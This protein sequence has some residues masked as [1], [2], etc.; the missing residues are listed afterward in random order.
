M[1][2]V[3]ALLVAL[4]LTPPQTCADVT[5]CRQ[6]ALDAAARGEYELFHDLAWRTAQKGR[7]NDP[8]LMA[9]LAR[10]QSLSGRPGDALVMLRRL[11]QM[12]AAIDATGDD[13]RRVR[14][15]PGWPEVEAMLKG[16]PPP[17]VEPAAT[18]PPPARKAAEPVASTAAPS[19]APAPIATAL[20]A[21]AA[22]EETL[23]A[24]L[25]SI[26]PAGLAYDA[27]SRRFIVGDR[28]ENKL[29][30]FDEVFKRATDMAGAA[31]AGFFG[32]AA[33]EIDA[34]RGDLWVAN[35]SAA[36][37]AALHKLQLVSGRVLFEVAVPAE[38][39]PAA[40]ADAAVLPDGRVLALDALGRR[41]LAL[42][43]ARA[44]QRTADIAVEGA[45][46]LAAEGGFAYIAHP[47]G[48][49]RVDLAS[50]NSSA[51][52]GAP[53]GLLRI[54]AAGRGLVAVQSTAS[55]HRIVRIRFASQG[56]KVA[57]VDVLDPSAPMPDP[58]AMTVVRD[59]V[60][61]IA[62]VDGTPV[63]RRVKVGR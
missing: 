15:L 9:L 13:F 38:L 56:T 16:V 37:G 51:M 29:V 60:C 3:L 24:A 31:S 62:D 42:S 40:F 2:S 44:F 8:A 58:S 50:R 49:L 53:A 5:S 18:P 33:I 52:T 22:E 59:A 6:E 7:P 39:G 55:G 12:G 43:P 21:A 61:Y 57:A 27:V 26:Q 30:I 25:A 47:A 1:P 4:A 41:L 46:S 28:R 35:S 17:A 34:V 11:A 20:S 19:S 14:S 45:T 48:L 23:P 36:R 32:V 10:A 54:R 63:M